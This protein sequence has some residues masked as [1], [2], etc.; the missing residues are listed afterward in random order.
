MTIKFAKLE[1]FEGVNF[2]CWK[3]KINFM[4]TTLKAAYVLTT[5]RPTEAEEGAAE[6]IEEIRRIH[7]WDNNDYI[8]KGHIL[9]GMSDALFDIHSEA[10]CTKEFW[11]STKLKYITEDASGKK[12]LV[13]EFKNY[14]MDNSRFVTEQYNELLGIF[15]QFKLRHMNMDEYITM[16]TIIDKLPPFWKNFKHNLKHQ[17]EELSLVQ[18]ASHIRIEESICV[19]ESD[20]SKKTQRKS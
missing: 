13:N 9:N 11:D 3:K 12:F 1:K 2:R 10:F 18:L 16:S 19:K 4:L 14:K 15:G 20:K 8:Y 5:P 17:K 6:T 7:K